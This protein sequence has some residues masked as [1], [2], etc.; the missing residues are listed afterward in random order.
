MEDDLNLLNGRQHNFFLMED[1]INL[2]KMDE[3]FIFYKSKTTLIFSSNG[4]QPQF[5]FKWKTTSKFLWM[6]D[7][8]QNLKTNNA[9]YNK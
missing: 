6:E 5:F 3:Y 4:R 1:N 7:D 2:K 8:L 9:P